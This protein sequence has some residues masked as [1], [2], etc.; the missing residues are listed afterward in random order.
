MRVNDMLLSTYRFMRAYPAATLGIGALLATVTATVNGLVMNGVVMGSDAMKAFNASAGNEVSA[1]VLEGLSDATRASLPWLMLIF[2]V[3]FV[4]QLAA[5]GV[6]T[7]AVL[8]SNRDQTVQPGELW[9][10]V[11]WQRLIAINGLILLLVLVANAVPFALLLFF[12]SAMFV[13]LGAMFAITASIVFSTALAVPAS[14][15]EQLGPRAALARSLVL[16]RGAWWRT[17]FALF[18]ANL[19]W[20]AIGNFI[21]SPI[22]AILGALAGGSRSTFAQV[23]ESLVVNII[24]GAVTLPGLA[25]MTTFIYF[26]RVVRTNQ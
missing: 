16:V 25:V 21:G 14:M 9:S 4:T 18:L 3:S 7:L 10:E 20:S 5:I 15:N 22:A 1:A 24:T 17:A 6:M 2:A 19:F 26:D 23:F 11:P 8:R 13:A 12:D